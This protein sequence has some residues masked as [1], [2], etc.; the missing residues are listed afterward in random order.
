MKEALASIVFRGFI[1]VVALVALVF[2]VLGQ[3]RP[4]RAAQTE[5]HVDTT[6]DENP[7]TTNG[8][9]SLREAIWNAN[10]NENGTYPDCAAGTAG[11]GANNDLIK[12]DAVGTYTL[13][14]GLD[15]MVGDTT[16]DGEGNTVEADSCDPTTASCSQIWRV[17]TVNAGTA[18]F[19]NMTIRHG[20]N[21]GGGVSMSNSAT[22]TLEHVTATHNSSGV[23]SIGG[24]IRNGGGTLTLRWSTVD[25]NK[26]PSGGGIYS[27]G[28]ASTTLDRSTVSNNEG[29]SSAA[30]IQVVSGTTYIMNSTIY[31]NAGVYG[32][33]VVATGAT[34]DVFNSTFASN[35][36]GI[37]NDG[38]N[39]GLRNDLLAD[40]S[41][42]DCYNNAGTIDFNDNTLIQTNG[43]GANDCGTPAISADPGNLDWGPHGAANGQEI[44]TLAFGAGSPAYRA[45]NQF[46]CDI[47]DGANMVDQRDFPRKPAGCDIGAWEFENAG[48]DFDR[49]AKA[50]PAKYVPS[51]G[52]VFYTRSSDAGAGSMFIGTDGDYVLNSDF[53]GDGKTDPAKYVSAAGAV[54]YFGSSD[55]AWHG[56]YVGND[57]QYIPASDFDGDGKTDPAKYVDAAGAVWYLGSADTTWH[58]LY[59]GS[60]NGGTYIPGSKFDGDNKT[61]PAYIDTS[62]NVWY[63]SSDSNNLHG[64]FIGSDGTYVP[65]SDYDGD[66]KTDPAKFVSPN[67]WYLASGNS[68]ALTGIPLGAD[69]TF[70]V[71]GSDFD[72]DGITDPAKFVSSAGAIWYQESG[73]SYNPVGVYMG[74]TATETYD[75]VN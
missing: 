53:D 10:N 40:N 8:H 49:D 60:L 39:L 43:G 64:L 71:P 52:A 5:I 28:G 33:M 75:I 65:R 62:G 34:A 38:G 41:T 37:R 56:V 59:I 6:S 67:I 74:D 7:A 31:N 11:T 57:G 20:A 23:A 4:A 26:A 46:I 42:Y 54:W 55:N 14:A 12:L 13:L 3:A 25:G 29:T 22:V 45:G 16:I 44:N 50:D 1:R 63:L 72:G 30:G 32:G 24:G 48:A 9:C 36:T 27:D 18:V 73:N 15:T 51:A 61:D 58:G 69:T 68:N 17:F 2:A 35:G 21:S 19:Q 66:G 70:V 47:S